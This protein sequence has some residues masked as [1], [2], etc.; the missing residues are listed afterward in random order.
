MS[1]E[2]AEKTEQDRK[3]I[4]QQRLQWKSV[5]YGETDVNIA[6]FKR[7]IARYGRIKV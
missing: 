5:I 1:K 2:V 3:L 6:R 4:E 7:Q